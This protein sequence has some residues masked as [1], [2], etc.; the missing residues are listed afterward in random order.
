MQ[1]FIINSFHHYK[2]IDSA[3]RCVL[4]EFVGDCPKMGDRP[5]FADSE[6]QEVA[7]WS[8]GEPVRFSYDLSQCHW[9]TEAERAD[10]FISISAVPPSQRAEPWCGDCFRYHLDDHSVA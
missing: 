2:V 3:G 6:G 10:N 5:P 8:H 7:S 9:L 4:L 1:D